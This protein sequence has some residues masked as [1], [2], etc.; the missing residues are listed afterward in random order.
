MNCIYELDVS[1]LVTPIWVFTDSKM[2]Y[3]LFARV[4]SNS[5]IK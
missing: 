5:I 1:V 4:V 3:L 2:V